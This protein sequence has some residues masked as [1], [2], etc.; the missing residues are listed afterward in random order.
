MILDLT[1]VRSAFP[2][3][4]DLAPLIQ[5]GQKDVLRGRRRGEAIVL[6]LLRSRTAEA[7]ARLTREIAAVASL[8][9]DYVPQIY[10]S[11]RRKIGT[12]QRHYLVEQFKEGKTY[13]E[14][15]ELQPVQHLSDVLR[16]ADLLLRA[17]CDFERVKLVHRDI[18]PENLIIEAGGK[19]WIIDFG[20]VRMLDLTS[21]T[22]SGAPIGT[23]TAGYGAPEQMRNMKPKI[24]ARTDLFSVGIVLYESLN[25]TNPHLAGAA[26]QLE[27]MRRV[28]TRDL[29]HLAL[30]ANPTG[31]LAAFIG[32]LVSRFA[33][34]RPQTA[35][36]AR[37]WFLEINAKLAPGA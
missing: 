29:P 10:E 22:P 12:E 6:K 11:G 17:C 18:K 33:S 21:L 37:D 31:E 9:C 20:I 30:S 14:V 24:D 4:T 13:R 16:L 2:E 3:L 25:G 34:R 27:V 28:D 8:R 36:A 35:S 1:A 23:F 5:S 32:S 7:A 19:I 15:L 26:D